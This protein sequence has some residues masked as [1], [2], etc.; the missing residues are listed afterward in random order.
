MVSDSPP[1]EDTIGITADSGSG[2]LVE[3]VLIKDEKVAWGDFDIHHGC[4]AIW[5]TRPMEATIPWLLKVRSPL[6]NEGLVHL[7]QINP[8]TK[9]QITFLSGS[10]L[11]SMPL[12]L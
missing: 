4:I 11:I 9:Y 8:P 3:D 6:T 5:A 12:L 1:N 7:I 2:D 10:G